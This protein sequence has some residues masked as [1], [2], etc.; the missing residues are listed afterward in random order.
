M[1]KKGKSDN[2]QPSK[3]TKPP[4]YKDKHIKPEQIS[5][6][7]DQ[8]TPKNQSSEE[9]SP[10]SLPE[11]IEDI[12]HE[13]HPEKAP[14][15][16]ELNQ[17]VSLKLNNPR[18]TIPEAEKILGCSKQNIYQRLATIGETWA[19]LIDSIE[20]FDNKEISLLSFK[21]KLALDSLTPEKLQKESAVQN[22]TVYCQLFDKQ[23]LLQEKS[24]E[25][26]ALGVIVEDR[27]AIDTEVEE[28]ESRL[29]ELLKARQARD[30][31]PG[32]DVIDVN[33]SNETGINTNK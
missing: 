16:I 7:Q 25:N 30:Q 24:T 13:A 18:L 5:T 27:K 22:S 10:E 23:R 12:D 4:E 19:S 11:V 9:N 31:L 6:I 15:G 17:I 8:E 1:A 21:K 2:K 28:K 20:K 33:E 14:K 3:D 26:I 29:Q 32:P